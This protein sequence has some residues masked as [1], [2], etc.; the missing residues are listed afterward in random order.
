M[1]S[2]G[3][4][5]IPLIVFV[6]LGWVTSVFAQDSVKRNYTVTVSSA[7][8]VLLSK[9]GNRQIIASKSR[10]FANAA[11][12][13]P[14]ISYQTPQTYPVNQPIAQLTPA[15]TGGAVPIGA[16]GQVTTFAGSGLSG[17]ANG[18]AAFSSFYQLYI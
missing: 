11:A 13:A 18:A 7:S 4:Y 14:V 1:I 2:F 8:K 3:K 10:V 17:S 9:A 6:L 15:N 5:V 16:Y 12:E